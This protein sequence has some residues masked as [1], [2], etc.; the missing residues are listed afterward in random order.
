MNASYGSAHHREFTTMES[1]LVVLEGDGI[2]GVGTA[3][4]TPGYS[5]QTHDEIAE[6]LL[7]DLLPA[8][9]DAQ[10]A[11]PN[12]LA[13]LLAD[14]R[15]APNAACALEMAYLD[16]FG[17]RHEQSLADMLWGARRRRVPLNGWVGIDDPDAMAAAAREWYEEGYRSLKIKL[18]G[19]PDEDVARVRAVCDA[20]ADDGMAVRADVNAG[21]DVE[22]AIRVARELESLPLVHLEQPVPKDDIEGLGRVTRSTSTAIMADECILTPADAF[23]ILR[24]GAADRIKVKILRMGGVRQTR[25]VL[26][27]AALAGVSCVLGHGFGLTPA[28]SAECQ[29]AAAH[30]NVFGPIESVGPLK[31]REEPFS[32][33]AF[34]AG[35]ALLPEGDGLGVELDEAA[36]DRFA[37]S[38]RTVER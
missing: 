36:I 24:T 12:A 6:S 9:L 8:L 18:S 29:L 37:D 19:D 13:D 15:E 32:E 20:V 16:W 21:Y 10:P 1:V 5:R 17:R 31:M 33:L 4:A 7:E 11:H 35:H 38:S 27:A 14:A 2:R 30:D 22:T 25:E 34:E 28:T 3:D 26:D 23:E